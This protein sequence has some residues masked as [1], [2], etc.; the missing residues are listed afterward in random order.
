M[1]T[2]LTACFTAI[3]PVRRLLPV[4]LA[5]LGTGLADPARAVPAAVDVARRYG[6]A[7][8]VVTRPCPAPAAAGCVGEHSQGFFVSSD[9][10]LATVLPGVKRDDVVDVGDAAAG[11]QGRVVASDDDGLALV[12]LQ[13]APDAPMTALAV[14]E[15]A[16]APRRWLIG[17]Q[18]DHRGV[19]A[20][21]GGEERGT[22]LLV[23]VP[24]GAPVLDEAL[25][26]VAIA[27]RGRG[28]GSIDVVPVGRLRTLATR[29]AREAA[30]AA[31]AGGVSTGP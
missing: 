8:V 22:T 16:G 19:Q 24:R 9:G 30:T 17:L 29:A 26:V 5:L 14:A 7:V 21:V 10:L 27:R 28:G 4:T 11:R 2:P 6:D 13:P 20:V 3:V 15:D 31:T 23:P 18:R 12:Q 1:A 25:Q